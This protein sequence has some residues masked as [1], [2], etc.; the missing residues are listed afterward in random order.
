MNKSKLLAKRLTQ[1]VA[2]ENAKNLAQ[3][4]RAAGVP[5]HANYIVF[6]DG[7]GSHSKH[8]GGYAGIV[9]ER[10]DQTIEVLYGCCTNSTSQEAELRP[11]FHTLCHIFRKCRLLK[12]SAHAHFFTDSKYAAGILNG[13]AKDPMEPVDFETNVLFYGAF[14][15][16]I[17]NG[18]QF[19]ATHIERNTIPPMEKADF[20]SK[21]A[22]ELLQNHEPM[23]LIS[24]TE[25]ATRDFCRFA[26]KS[27][28]PNNG[29]KT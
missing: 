17:R 3:L 14:V 25:E 13:I 27:P 16:A 23:P 19:T 12:T 28:S 15:A 2:P 6:T 5:K 7:S 10:F 29:D 4:L 8:P 24:D 21:S 22:R 9:V 11:L 26:T 18:V 20:L 1:K